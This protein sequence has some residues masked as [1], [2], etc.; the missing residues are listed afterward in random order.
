MQRQ[1]IG[2][3]Q[4]LDKIDSGGQGAVYKV[5]DPSNGQ[6]AALKTLLPNGVANSDG[7]ERFRRESELTA[8]IA[9]PNVIR[10]LDNGRDGDH[11]F[12]TMELLPSSVADLIRSVGQLPV[13]RAVDIC[14]QAA[15]GLHAAN[16]HGIIHRDIKPSN[17]LVA[18]DGTAK[19]TDFGLARASDLKTITTPNAVMGTVD[20]MS[21]EQAQGERPDTRSDIYSLGIVLFETLTGSVPL[22][23]WGDTARNRPPLQFARTASQQLWSG[24]DDA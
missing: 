21:P 4:I 6:V 3:Y 10:I 12:I 1:T 2:G 16:G 7:I 9:H 13:A 24:W 11:H 17:L 15:L 23:K 19:V 5:W 18:P 22:P 20:Y 8:Q 14:R